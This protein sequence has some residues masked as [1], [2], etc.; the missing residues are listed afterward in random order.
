MAGVL[1]FA[2]YLRA[3]A[4]RPFAWDRCDCCSWACGWVL[5]RRG[6]DPSAPWRGRYRTAR[7]ALRHIRK[8]GDFRAVVAG[9]MAAAG[10]APTESP[11]PGDIG[12]V[13]TAQGLALGLRVARGWACKSKNGLVVADFPCV[14]GWTV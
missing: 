2:A 1:S 14:A 6:V 8:G 10:L 13:S 12:I 5:V 11:M 9:A 4:T 7:G 3:G